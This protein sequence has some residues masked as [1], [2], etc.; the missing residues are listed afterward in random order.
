MSAK[1]SLIMNKPQEFI[2]IG[3]D[4]AKDKLDIALDDHH[5]ISVSNDKKGF[6]ALLKAAL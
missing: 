2:M 5:T 1:G 6:Q 4:V 3:I